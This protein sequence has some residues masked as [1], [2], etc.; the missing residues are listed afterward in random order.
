MNILNIIFFI[1]NALVLKNLFY[2]CWIYVITTPLYMAQISGNQNLLCEDYKH[3]RSKFR[4]YKG[5]ELST[6]KQLIE[7]TFSGFAI[8]IEHNHRER[9]FDIFLAKKN[10]ETGKEIDVK[11]VD[12]FRKFYGSGFYVTLLEEAYNHI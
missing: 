7:Y 11:E 10:K 5:F 8:K 6:L 9:R 2:I 3:T 4:Y 1:I 12:R